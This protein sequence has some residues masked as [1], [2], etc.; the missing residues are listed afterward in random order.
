MGRFQGHVRDMLE[1]GLGKKGPRAWIDISSRPWLGLE[2][3]KKRKNLIF[4]IRVCGGLVFGA[5]PV[6]GEKAAGFC[7]VGVW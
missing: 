2:V 4:L 5:V 3:C 7:L 1:L 6:M